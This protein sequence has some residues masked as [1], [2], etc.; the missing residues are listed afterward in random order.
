MKRQFKQMIWVFVTLISHYRRHPG[1]ALT[2]GLGLISGVALWAAVQLINDHA[3][4]SYAEADQLLGA[5]ARYWIRSDNGLG[6]AVAD[7][8]G[9]RRAGFEQLYPVIETQVR[10][11]Q[12]R[13]V[14]IIAT[15]LLA[16]PVGNGIGSSA[17]YSNPFGAS[18]WLA[19]IQAD[20][21]AWY[22]QSLASQLG[23]EPGQ[24][25][26]LAS[27]ERLPPALIQTQT[28]QGQRVFMD[29]AAAMAIL[30]TDT[31][32]Y[33]GVGRLSKLE[34]L[35][36][37][38]LLP[39]TLKLVTNHQALDLAQ[40]TE[41]LHTHLTAL[42][43]LSFA[44]GLFIVFNAVRF[45][46]LARQGTLTTLREMGISLGMLSIAIIAESLLWTLFGTSLGLVMGYALSQLLLPAMAMS[47]QSLYAAELGSLIGIQP[48]QVLLAFGLSLAG[49]VLALTLP[50]WL[51]ARESIRR[52]RDTAAQWQQDQRGI[53]WLALVAMGLLGLAA[54]LYPW[55]ASIEQGFLMLALLMFGGALLLPWLV[56]GLI[57]T[58]ARLL[59]KHQWLLRWAVSDALAQLPHLRIALMAL[60]LTLTANI[61]VTTLVGSFRTALGDWLETRLA[62]DIYVQSESLDIEAI[63]QAA[64]LS[65]YSPRIGL[66]LRWQ[67]RP[68]SIR[69]LDLTAPDTVDMVLVQ[70]HGVLDHGGQNQQAQDQALQAWRT[71]DSP[72][73]PILAN[74]QVQYL[75]HTPL[76]SI[77]ELPT[78][79]GPRRFKIVGYVH[80]YGNSSLAFYLPGETVMAHWPAAELLGAGLWLSEPA[81]QIDPDWLSSRLSALGVKPGQWVLQGEI[82]RISFAIF[83]RTFAITATLNTLTL[84]V[85]GL[86][87]LTALLA[88]HQ[89]RLPEYAHWRSM[90]VNFSQWLQIAALPLLLMLAVTLLLAL[91]LGFSLS[92]LLINKLNVIAFGWTMP[93]LWSWWPLAKL[94]ILTLGIVLTTLTVS[95]VRVRQTLPTAIK[96]LAGDSG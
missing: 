15:D 17:R 56:L 12:G 65:G 29:I 52:Q 57:K 74:E 46:L 38:A 96:Q 41:S 20:Y 79:A 67:N 22:P 66:D 35:R 3:R 43:L 48:E 85:A 19:L 25:L 61:G 78:P 53:R 63:K 36:L 89:Q 31:F 54:A 82:K 58:C 71:G 93:L 94:G 69:G 59:P 8:I 64:W 34:H 70:D 18:S 91:P 84:L 83:D 47:L 73:I 95:V 62:A 5:E 42:G 32:S 26:V 1:Q 6:V 11:A 16:L 13:S 10:D 76:G 75:A 72:V 86:S 87:L 9:L 28:Q 37:A 2:M 49:V 90:G 4:S 80:D 14:A 60:L 44:V 21:Q 92:W 23:I 40:V 68:T 50:L 81:A 27:G 33:L 7:Y 30:G 45:S 77:I 51:R 24:Q 39:A 55:M 88:V